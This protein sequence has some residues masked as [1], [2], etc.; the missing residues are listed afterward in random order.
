MAQLLKIIMING[1]LPGVV[2]LELDGHTNICGSNA[3]GKTTLQR[4]IP[5]FYGER[6]NRV[7]PRTRQNF[8]KYYLPYKNS[9]VIYEYQR[10]SGDKA[11]VVLTK[12]ADGVDYRFI[13]AAYD[14]T[15]YLVDKGEAQGVIAL[16]YSAWQAQLKS[17]QVESSHKISSTSEYR[18]IILNDVKADRSQRRETAKAKQLA[19]QFSLAQ[20]GVRLR[21]IEKLVSAVHAKE[22]KMDTLK[23][24]LAAILEEDG[25]QRPDN[26]FTR[27][28]INAWLQDMQQFLKLDVLQQQFDRTEQLNREQ[29]HT[30]ASLWQLAPHVEADLEQLKTQQA[31]DEA[32]LQ[33][34]NRIQAENEAAYDNDRRQQND[35]L[36]SAQAALASVE[37]RLQDAQSRY[38][39]FL[40]R[41]LDGLQRKV[42]KLP[43]MRNELLELTQQYQLFME[44]HGDVQ[45]QLDSHKLKLEQNLNTLIEQNQRKAHEKQLQHRQVLLQ[46]HDAIDVLRQSLQPK[47]ES[48]SDDY[49]ARMDALRQQLTTQQAQLNVSAYTHSEQDEALLAD[50]RV[51]AAQDMLNGHT[52]E[53]EQLQKRFEQAR[54]KQQQASEQLALARQQEV[55]AQ[56]LLQYAEQQLTPATGSLHQFLRDNVD[57]WEAALGKVLAPE[58]LAR[59]DLMPQKV[60]SD[61]SMLGVKLDLAAVDL[62]PFAQSEAELQANVEQAMAQLD[63]AA[64]ARE[65]ASKALAQANEQ[66]KQAEQAL[67]HGQQRKR[68][69]RN[70]LDYAK[71]AKARL[72]AEQQKRANERQVALK[73]SSEKLAQELDSLAEQRADALNALKRDSR[74]QE[75]ELKAGFQD[76][77][78]QLQEAIDE[79]HTDIQRRREQSK[80]RLKALE[81]E[82]ETKLAAKGVD[83]LRLQALKQ[84]KEALEADIRDIE[85]QRESLSDYQQFMRI[86]WAKERPAWL[87]QEQQSKQT[88]RE[89]QAAL[90]QLELDYKA[91]REQLRSQLA[92]I[93]E[94]QTK[95]SAQLKDVHAVLMRLLELPVATEV[96][97]TSGDNRQASGDVAERIARCHQLFDDKQKLEKEIDTLVATL[98]RD[99]RAGANAK[100]LE[101]IDKA[102]AN[103]GDQASTQARVAVLSDT[104]QI[105]QGQQQQ[106]IQ[107]GHTI[108][109]ALDQFFTVFNNIHKRV[110]EYSRRITDA[111]TD[112]LTLDGIDHS[113]VKISSTIDELGFWQPLKQM[114]QTYRQWVSSGEL[115]PPR[116]YLA[117]LSDVGELLKADQEYSI[118][119]LLKLQLHLVERGASLVIKN[120]RQ[121]AESSSHGMAYLILCKFLL[122]FTR[123]LRPGQANVA[124][125]WPIDEIGTLAYHNVEKLFAACDSNQ[126]HIVGAFPNPESDVLLLFK[127]RYLIEPHANHPSKG[128]LK[129]IK[130]R[131]SPLAEKLQAK[132]QHGEPA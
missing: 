47:L 45:R 104:L 118:E 58:L 115:L 22:G 112:E 8:D 2:E 98:E 105:L 78:M 114:T 113:E 89:S 27:T 43:D 117:Q 97:T 125:H 44:E 7:V 14:P 77:L 37:A 23:S 16:E 81:Q 79:L 108:G 59:T 100:F 19:R 94:R 127:N 88:I 68:E 90:A 51:D 84:E 60:K 28:K 42:E 64:A 93:K 25:Y 49:R 5:V 106:V 55:N 92:E 82:F 62:P 95:A 74:E 50:K 103:L 11:Q 39:D 61:G 87:E 123:L 91:Q 53:L 73:R 13:D 15:H 1:H 121:L 56:Q 75:M 102:F 101:F 12:R 26:T 76:Q 52:L 18:S 72:A 29:Q 33:G 63:D 57:G 9:Y 54:G 65:A 40:E 129:R 31:D 107:Q 66:L 41:D 86:T 85:S 10:P 110:G 124:L 21:H 20:E 36:Q 116:D 35:V 99:L 30:L 34:L 128:Q 111:V 131:L 119:S 80:E 109:K 120:D 3:S 4:M 83:Q 38:D 24:M 17:A 96:P 126:I 132:V 32:K 71:D 6:P 69:L 122:A 130:P 48:I 46:Q 67:Q 70:E